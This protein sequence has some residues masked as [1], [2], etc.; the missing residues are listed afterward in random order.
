MSNSSCNC[1]LK[2]RLA[3]FHVVSPPNHPLISM[4]NISLPITPNSGE[5]YVWQSAGQPLLSF[6]KKDQME[7]RKYFD[8]IMANVE[9]DPKIKEYTKVHPQTA[10]DITMYHL[11]HLVRVGGQYETMDDARV[12]INHVKKGPKPRP[13][14]VTEAEGS[15]VRLFGDDLKNFTVVLHGEQRLISAEDFFNKVFP[16]LRPGTQDQVYLPALYRDHIQT[17]GE[18]GELL[19]LF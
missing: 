6:P 10:Q 16:R 3:I 12:A 11:N 1:N 15:Q 5:S 4:T 9:K 19:T 7:N 17:N 14:G 8:W 18:L 13:S 2:I